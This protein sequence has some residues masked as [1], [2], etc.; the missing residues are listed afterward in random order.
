MHVVSRDFIL[1]VNKKSK[2]NHACMRPV[3]GVLLRTKKSMALLHIRIFLVLLSIRMW[4]T[5]GHGSHPDCSMGEW[6]KWG[7]KCDPNTV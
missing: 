5:S 7:N 2:G 1:K 3:S 6:A 4:V